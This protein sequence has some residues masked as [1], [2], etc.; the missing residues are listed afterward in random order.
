MNSPRCGHPMR[1]SEPPGWGA[2]LDDPACGRRLGH[3]GR[4]RSAT[5]MAVRAA[6][7]AA[8][9][10]PTGSPALAA[11]IR[12]ARVQAGKSQL[13]LAAVLGVTQ[14]AVQR[15]ETARCVPSGENWVQLEFALGPLGIVREGDPRPEAAEASEHAA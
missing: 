10:R 1:W 4:H 3:P 8:Y 5:A 14:Q 12:R 6:R 13:A 2:V 9:D 11:A 7:R 15:W